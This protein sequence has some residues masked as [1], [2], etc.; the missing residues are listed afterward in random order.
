MEYTFIKTAA[1]AAL[2]LTAAFTMTSCKGGAKTAQPAEEVTLPDNMCK[3]VSDGFETYWIGDNA[4]PRNNDVSLFNGVTDE[5]VKELGLENGAPASMNTFFIKADGKNLLF[6]TGFGSEGSLLLPSLEVIGVKPEDVDA[7]FMTHLHG[8]H[9]GGLAKDGV[10]VFPNAK[11]YLSKA[12]YETM[13]GEEIFAPYKDNVVLCE[14]GE[15]LPYGVKAIEATGHTPGH[16]CFLKGDVLIAGDIMH[17]VA[18]QMA[19][20]EFSARF[21]SDPEAS[22]ATRVKIVKMAQENNLLLCG[23]HF[24]KGGVIDYRK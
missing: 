9:T 8:D 6:D 5:I 14:F 20:P 16:L 2:C 21:D 24:P 3:Y 10:A 7:I 12:E 4:E 23:M 22:A 18:L 1:A 17:A 11:V 13:G 15:T 19:H